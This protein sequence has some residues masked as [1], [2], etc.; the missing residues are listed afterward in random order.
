VNE[1][2]GNKRVTGLHF[3]ARGYCVCTV[4]LDE[5][6]VRKYIREQEKAENQQKNLIIKAS[7]HP[8]KLL[9]PSRLLRHDPDVF[10]DSIFSY[11]QKEDPL[12]GIQCFP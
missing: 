2:A 1:R 9:Q 8:Y 10:L 6:T 11:L 7:Q 3:W 12:D 5:A 4:G